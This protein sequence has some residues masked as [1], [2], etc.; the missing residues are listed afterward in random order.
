MP[1]GGTQLLKEERFKGRTS[2]ACPLPVEK[3]T[4]GGGECLLAASL[5]L[6]LSQYIFVSLISR[7]SVYDVLRRVCTH[8][9]VP[10]APPLMVF[11]WPQ[12]SPLAPWAAFWGAELFTTASK[13]SARS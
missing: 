13:A 6:S 10:S 12:G 7:D 2:S 4:R 8:L 9:Q 3:P 11:R 1:A 5:S